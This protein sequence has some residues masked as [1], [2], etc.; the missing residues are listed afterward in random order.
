MTRG[1]KREGAGRPKG[2]TIPTRVKRIP[3]DIPDELIDNLPTLRDIL[4]HWED[5]CL[6]VGKNSARH[7]FLKQAIEEIRALGY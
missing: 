2:V 3:T 6:T 7:Y 5:E 1:G 4:N